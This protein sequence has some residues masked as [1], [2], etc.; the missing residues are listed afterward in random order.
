MK[1]KLIAGF[2]LLPLC[3][4]AQAAPSSGPPIH[5]LYRL[6]FRN[7]EALDA[8]AAKSD[9]AG[10]KGGDEARGWFQKSLHLTPEEAAILK[11]HARQ[12]NQ[13]LDQHQQ[14]AQPAIEAVRRRNDPSPA[15]IPAQLRL[16]N[17]AHGAIIGNCI[18]NLHA[19][20]GDRV[21]ADVDLFVH[22]SFARNVSA[23]PPSGT[24]FANMPVTRIGAGDGK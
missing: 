10:L 22:T 9:A 20:L 7:I 21:F 3:L 4:G 17:R 24:P 8:S 18:E 16:S 15:V 2:C 23:V 13:V 6:F 5:V 1:L 14:K 11:Q 12:C 19:A